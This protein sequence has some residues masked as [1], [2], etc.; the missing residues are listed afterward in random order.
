MGKRL[1]Q[2]TEPSVPPSR[3][4]SSAGQRGRLAT[5]DQLD[6][7]IGHRA[8]PRFDPCPARSPTVA[9]GQGRCP[10]RPASGRC[11]CKATE[12]RNNGY[13][14][15]RGVQFREGHRLQWTRRWPPGRFGPLMGDRQ[16]RL[17]FPGREPEGRIRHHPRPEGAAGGEHPPDVIAFLGDCREEAASSPV[18]PSSSSRRYRREVSGKVGHR[19]AGP[20]TAPP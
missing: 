3:P 17:P 19:Q 9:L 20:A 18:D 16:Q 4:G 10:P 2:A 5:E 6:S 7:G 13:R 11:G 12:G 8:G 1:G 15:G 14:H